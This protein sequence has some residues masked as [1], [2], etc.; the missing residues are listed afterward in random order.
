MEDQDRPVSNIQNINA[1]NSV[2]EALKQKV[3][4]EITQEGVQQ[5]MSQEEAERR[6]KQLESWGDLEK[7]DPLFAVGKNL[8]TKASRN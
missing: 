3:R 7:E 2:G 8:Q 4:K 5:G 1:R 6:T